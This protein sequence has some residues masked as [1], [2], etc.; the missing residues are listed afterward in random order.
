MISKHKTT[1]KAEK[2]LTREN[3]KIHMMLFSGCEVCSGK[4]CELALIA[5]PAGRVGAV[6]KSEGTVSYNLDQLLIVGK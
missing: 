2:S 5:A 4:N 6:F 1:R 3:N